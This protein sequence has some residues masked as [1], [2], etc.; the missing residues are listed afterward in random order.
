MIL[1]EQKREREKK[2]KFLRNKLIK[3][4][5]RRRSRLF[6]S[7]VLNLSS[8]LSSSII[9]ILDKILENSCPVAQDHEVTGSGLSM[10]HSFIIMRID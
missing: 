3:K 9:K 5:E 2:E 7:F 4:K 8:P 10:P 1:V 6:S